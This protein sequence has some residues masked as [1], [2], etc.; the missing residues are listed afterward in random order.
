VV[1]ARCGAA[2]AVLKTARWR[3]RNG[4]PFALCDPCWR[5]IAGAVWIVPGPVICF[6]TC[7][8]CGEWAS[9]RDLLGAKP[10]GKWSAPTG[11][12]VTCYKEG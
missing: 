9:V 4:G 8:R 7:R 10:G 3:D 11:T 2:A 6:G 1:C 12:C 5:P